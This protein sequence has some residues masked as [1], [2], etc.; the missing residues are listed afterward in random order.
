MPRISDPANWTTP[1]SFV[2]V[3]DMH[4]G[5]PRSYRF[6]PAWNENWA[7][8]REQIIELDPA[9]VLVGGD[10]TRDGSTH[11]LELETMRRDLAA[12]PFPAHVIPGNHEVGNKFST[13]SS[14]A[15]RP[16]YVRLYES[17][18]GPSQWSVLHRGVRF[19]GC[20]AFLLGSGLPQEATLRS[21]LE[22]QTRLPHAPIHVWM[23]HPA[24]FADRF[25]EP[26]WN[27]STH[28]E[29]WYFVLDGVHRRFLVEI[30]RA[31]GATHIIT[32][33]IHC[34]RMV[35]LGGMKISFAP[36]TAFPQWADRWPDG[37][38]TLGFLRG[39]VGPEGLAIR[40]IPLRRRSTRKG[41]GPGGNPGLE[42]RDYSAAWEQPPLDVEENRF[43]QNTTE[44]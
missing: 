13:T 25:D 19:S 22:E 37:D 35:D 12:L 24:L 28:R 42:G 6:Q 23:I 5:T 40:F 39:D 1:W 4:V 43:P 15:I 7:V 26:D 31:T 27:P 2:H 38:P 16:D 34:R 20:D 30:F 29:E 3:A 33:H 32:A 41:Y 14:V 9:L 8:A 17:V 10:L 36:S 44:P 18:F 11:R 21:W